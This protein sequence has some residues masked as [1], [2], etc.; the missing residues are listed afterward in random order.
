M[1]KVT[2]SPAIPLSKASTNQIGGVTPPATSER[3]IVIDQ[4][5]GGFCAV[6]TGVVWPLAFMTPVWMQPWAIQNAIDHQLVALR[7]I[8]HVLHRQ[9]QGIVATTGQVNMFNRLQACHA[10]NSG[11]STIASV[12][13]ATAR[14]GNV[15]PVYPT[16]AGA[17]IARTTSDST[18]D[19]VAI[20][21]SDVFDSI[22]AGTGSGVSA[23]AAGHRVTA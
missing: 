16:N 8:Q 23:I 18:S 12:D 4:Q 20:G 1:F 6:R 21:D 5:L 19:A 10:A 2:P 9:L 15:L 7:Q 14:V 3:S 22:D 13:R 11:R 17:A